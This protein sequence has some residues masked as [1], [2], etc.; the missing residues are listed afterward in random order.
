MISRQN[1]A[2]RITLAILLLLGNVIA[3]NAILGRLRGARVDLT[4]GRIFTLAP[5]TR[6][7]LQE[8]EEPLEIFFFHT[9]LD[10]LHEKLR[11][12]VGPLSDILKEFAAASDGRVTTRI[13][14]WDTAAKEIQDRASDQFG[15]KPVGIQMQTSDEETVRNTYFSVVVAYGD[16]FQRFDQSELY[17]IVQVGAGLDIR[18]ELQNVEYLV[19]KAIYKV[20]RGFQSIGAALATSD[21]EARIDLYFSP[22]DE[23][24]KFLQKVPDYAAKVSKKLADEAMGRLKFES[25]AVSAKDEDAEVRKMLRT[26]YRLREIPTDL[27]SEKGIYSYAVITVGKQHVP[28]ALVTMGEEMT[29]FEVREALEGQLKALVPGFLMTIGVMSPDASKSPMAGMMG[30]R[31]PPEEYRE[32]VQAL[33]QEFDVRRIDVGEGRPI[34]RQVS[35]LL[36]IKPENLSD[37]ALYEID[38][39]LMRGGRLV[40]CAD[41]VSFDIERAWQTQDANTLRT[42]AAEGVRKFLRHMGADVGDSMLL[43]T[44]SE[45]VTKARRTRRGEVEFY[46]EQL[47]YFAYVE[48]PDGFDQTHDIVAKQPFILVQWATPVRP[49]RAEPA[50]EGREARPGVPEGVEAREIAWTSPE[51]S[52]STDLAQAQSQARIR[53]A[54]PPDAARNPVALV[55]RGT[56]PSYFAGK[57]VPGEETAP[58]TR[59]TDSAASRP[60]TRERGIRLDRSKETSIVV[61]GDSDF[62]S[63]IVAGAFAVDNAVLRQNLAFVR[64]AIDFGGPEARLMAI[65]NRE[66]VQRPLLG[67]RGFDEEERQTRTSLARWLALTIPCAALILFGVG[68]AIVRWNRRPLDLPPIASGASRTPS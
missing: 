24:P 18:V 34:P 17:R 19:A 11:P 5:Q 2:L 26:K 38:Q 12:L 15:V 7:L 63:P 57:P 39:F 60:E 21:L 58:E 3:F 64:N 49:A 32:V 51:S 42:V 61:I 4:E 6:E 16:Q 14:E 28:V 40:V 13:V 54:P 30:Q 9:A 65:R 45:V 50:A 52:T 29:E 56:F 44:K 27:F 47:P 25:H 33:E 53:Y 67:L 35:A 43:D 36:I 48:A 59:G 41:A 1:H 62:L 20:V 66:N 55:L 68:W 31:Q 22:A 37:K 23:L 8:P 46:T 10:R